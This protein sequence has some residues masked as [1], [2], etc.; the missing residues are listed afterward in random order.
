L[1]GWPAIISTNRRGFAADLLQMQR[2]PITNSTYP[3]NNPEPVLAAPQVFGQ[4]YAEFFK[5]LFFFEGLP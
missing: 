5:M 3:R 1:A 2:R 4:P